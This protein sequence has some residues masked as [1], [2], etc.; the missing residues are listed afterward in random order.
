[1]GKLGFILRV[2]VN[3]ME[4]CPHCPLPAFTVHPTLSKVHSP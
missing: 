3:L 4:K 2:S 1:M